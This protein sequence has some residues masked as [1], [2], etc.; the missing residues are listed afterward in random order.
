MF[1]CLR[2]FVIED[3]KWENSMYKKRKERIIFSLYLFILF[4]PIYFISLYLL[5]IFISIYYLFYYIYLFIF[6]FQFN[7]FQK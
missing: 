7:Y 1:V 2:K 4:V 3:G 6:L 5:F